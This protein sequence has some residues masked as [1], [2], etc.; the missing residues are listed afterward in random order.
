MQTLN[1]NSKMNATTIKCLQAS[2]II[3]THHVRHIFMSISKLLKIIYL[4]QQFV[5]CS[6]SIP[7]IKKDCYKP[8]EKRWIVA[9]INPISH[10]HTVYHGTFFKVIID[11]FYSCKCRSSLHT[12]ILK[13]THK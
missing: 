9:T 3:M 4:M 1:L 7:F 11:K 10:G 8:D 13:Q 6:N 12:I 5:K 2:Q